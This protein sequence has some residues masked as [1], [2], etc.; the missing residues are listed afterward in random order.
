L[1]F[2]PAAQLYGLEFASVEDRVSFREA[3]TASLYDSRS[4]LIE[5]KSDA[6]QDAARRNELKH[7]IKSSKELAHA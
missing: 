3:F 4:Y 5:Y 1:D 7:L 6:R 2:A